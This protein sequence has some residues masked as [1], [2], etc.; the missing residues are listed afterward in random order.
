MVK[1]SLSRLITLQRDHSPGWSFL[2]DQ[3][4]ESWL[5]GRVITSEIDQSDQNFSAQYSVF[6]FVVQ[7][8]KKLGTKV[9]KNLGDQSPNIWL[10]ILGAK[11][12]GAQTFIFSRLIRLLLYKGHI[13]LPIM[14]LNKLIES[15][16][17]AKIKKNFYRHI[18]KVKQI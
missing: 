3:P 6:W 11:T 1:S 12:L 8:S 13:E 16:T 10:I 9:P 5:T 14:P 2:P 15:I 7:N 18:L 4:G 17:F